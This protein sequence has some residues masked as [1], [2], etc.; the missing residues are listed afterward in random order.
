MAI[1]MT[2]SVS[3]ALC[4]A[5]ALGTVGTVGCGTILHP[6]RRGQTGGRID[7]GVA[8]MNGLWCL[9]FIIPGVVGFIIDFNN[10][11]I[12]EPGGR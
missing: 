12:Y 3:L 9:V 4:A 2:K 8:V 7:T 10:G 11:T 5:L 1:V 6:E